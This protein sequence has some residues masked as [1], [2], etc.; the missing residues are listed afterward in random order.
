MRARYYDSAPAHFLSRDPASSGD[1]RQMD[2]Y[3]FAMNNPVSNHDA[4]GLS[5]EGSPLSGAQ[6]ALVQYMTRQFLSAIGIGG[7]PDESA[8][9][10]AAYRD[11]FQNLAFSKTLTAGTEGQEYYQDL[12]FAIL[13]YPETYLNFLHDKMYG[14]ISAGMDFFDYLDDD[15]DPFGATSVSIAVFAGLL[16]AWVAVQW[17][18]RKRLAC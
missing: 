2:P 8:L 16:A 10:A 3:Q 11:G 18:R 14:Y 7:A 15:Y 6:Q 17:V 9:Y 5:A 12:G 1:P 13:N 4:R